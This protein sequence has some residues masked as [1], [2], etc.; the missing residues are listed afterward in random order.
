MTNKRVALVTGASSGIGEATAIK[1]VAVGY[2]VYGTSRRGAESSEA[3]F[4]MLALDVTNDESVEN[5]VAELLRLEGRID[6]LVNNAGFGFSPA[7][8]EESSIEQAK[9]MFDTNF[10]GLVRMTR[11]VV[12][13]M[14]R[15]GGGRIINIGSILG[16]VP[17]PYAA[18][19]CAS[20]HAVEGYSEALDHEL[21]TQGI[22]VSVIEPAYVKT[23]FEVNNIEPDSKIGEYDV[24]R[25]KLVHVV[26]EA[27]S[28]ADEPEEAADVVVKAAQASNPKLRYTSGKTARMF[29]F[30]RRFAPASVLDKGIR[31]NLQLDA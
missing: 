26:S 24:I 4:P 22:R 11:T 14:R 19:Y 21:R 18:L 15:Q 9:A 27:M 25:A 2:S 31:K 23:K 13:Y 8:A 20:K 10:H 28:K 29:A 30:L 1:L 6:L 17:V 12:P 7:A 3:R 5:A 16:V